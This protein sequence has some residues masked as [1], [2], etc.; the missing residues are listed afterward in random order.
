MGQ[1]TLA[2][3]VRDLYEPQIDQ[4]GLEVVHEEGYIKAETLRGWGH[5]RIVV[6]PLFRD[7]AAFMVE[8]H[9]DEEVRIRPK[10]VDHGCIARM[11]SDS[12]S[13]LPAS[14]RHASRRQDSFAA[15][16]RTGAQRAFSIA[17][18]ECYRTTSL[19]FT[20]S[21][22]EQAGREHGC[23]LAGLFEEM[24]A[25]PQ[26]ELPFELVTLMSGLS[27]RQLGMPS[28]LM[29]Y[30]AKLLE[31]LAILDSHA[32]ARGEARERQGEERQR[33][34][35]ER[36]KTIVE[37]NLSQELTLEQIA[38]RLF[39]SRSYL[40]AAFREE[41]GTSIGAWAKELRMS[42]AKA[43]LSNPEHSIAYIARAVGFQRVGSLSKAFKA[44][45]GFTPSQWREL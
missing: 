45:T 26:D 44:S 1:M 13:H 43:M 16:S 33:L 22:L 12:A 23:E 15:Y 31:A 36:A 5:G 42:R 2:D 6:Q 34:V 7:C 10:S 19:C 38:S 25:L 32:K 17:P 14:R 24:R 3:G 20:P 18:G 21:F 28:S 41:T 40:S 8:I 9:P 39:V 4:L 30:R 27:D 37:Q 29:Y 11:S 35:V